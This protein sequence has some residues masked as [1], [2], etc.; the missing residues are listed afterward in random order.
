MQ[1]VYCMINTTVNMANQLKALYSSC[2]L[3]DTL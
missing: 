2:V 3:R 1:G